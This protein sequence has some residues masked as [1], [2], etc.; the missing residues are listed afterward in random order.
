M[1]V[2]ESDGPQYNRAGLASNIKALAKGRDW[3]PQAAAF[4]STIDP[5][6]WYVA[7]EN[8]GR[9]ATEIGATGPLDAELVAVLL[10]NLPDIISA[11]E[12]E[13]AAHATIHQLGESA[14]KAAGEVERLR[15]ALELIAT[16]QFSAE[17]CANTARAAFTEPTDEA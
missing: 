1:N 2:P 16:K 6:R 14:A 15:E 4:R 8:T 5:E 10:R 17:H 3:L 9:F 13:D 11:L 7:C 12:Q